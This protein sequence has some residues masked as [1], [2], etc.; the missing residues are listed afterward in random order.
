MTVVLP[1]YPIPDVQAT[2][3]PQPAAS[4]SLPIIPRRVVNS[5]ADVASDR[6]LSVAGAGAFVPFGY[7]AFRTGPL[8]AHVADYNGRLVL[9]LVWC[10]GQVE[11][12]DGLQLSDGSDVPAAIAIT[13]YT[14]DPTQGVDPALSAAIDGWNNA[15][16]S[17]VRGHVVGLAYSVVSIPGNSQIGIPAFVADIRG[18][19]VYDPRDVGQSPTDS[20]TWLY[21]DNPALA[22]ADLE[23]SKLY[24][25]GKSIDWSSVES[26]ADDC[27]ELVQGIE[28]RRTVGLIINS[29]GRVDAWVDTLSTYAGCFVVSEG[30]ATKL[31]SNR[32]PVVSRALTDA[33]IVADDR[34]TPKLTIKLRG[35]S[36]SPTVVHVVYTETSTAEHKD[37]SAYAYMAGVLDGS[38]EW[39]ESV[40]RLPGI[41]RYSQAQ[42]EAVER[43]NALNLTD[44][45]VRFITHDE[46]L[47][48]QV[49]DVI[50][51]TSWRGLTNKM[52]R[53]TDVV[54]VSPGRWQ[55]SATEYQTNVYSDNVETAP[56]FTDT[57]LLSPLDPPIPTGVVAVEE[58]YQLENGTF[59]SRLSITWDAVEYAYLDHFDVRVSDATALVMLVSVPDPEST[60]PPVQDNV[61]YTVNVRTVSTVGASSEWVTINITADG[62]YLIPSDVPALDGFEVGGEVRLNW[63]PSIDVDIW[64]YEIRYCAPAVD[65]DNA[66]LLDRVDALRL[67]TRDVPA[68]SWDFLVKAVDSVGQYSVNPARRQLLVTLDTGAFLVDEHDFSAPILN[69]VREC[70]LGRVDGVRRFVTEM[71]D[72][73]A[74]MFPNVMA[75]Y[76]EPLVTYHSSGSS[77]IL[78]ETWD[79]GTQISGT[80]LAEIDYSALT[81]AVTV[82]LELSTDGVLWDAYANLTAKVTARYARIRIGAAT[83]STIL[84]TIP[85]M[86]V[87]VDAV[88]R[89]ENGASTSS[90]TLA[91]TI[92]CANEYAAAQSILI[93]PL[94]TTALSAVVDNIVVG[95]PTTFDVY[96][97]NVS[98]TQVANDF[99]WHFGGV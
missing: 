82:A 18:R 12:I 76:T 46:A 27:D 96:I 97:F 26:V 66:I 75:A 37:E 70:A 23:S 38:T 61:F 89:E 65:W 54:P 79:A 28:A 62:K 58:V 51:L 81:G 87:R 25:R 50:A 85:A 3:E 45:E 59:Q 60:T 41:N 20:A 71:G 32:P 93:T 24:G 15:L 17:V 29:Q 11:S 35:L 84:A 83:T 43:L 22:L 36:N 88:P 31:V 92:T 68:G 5:V 74:S 77:E 16:V 30:S 13:H 34:G 64:R 39:R 42:R 69:N 53:I 10:L 4:S 33:D 7:G 98:G 19:R 67:V 86:R 47:A 1:D 57:D 80:W 52:L 63:S 49:G 94:G 14:G 40:V 9:L 44:L 8:M 95:N 91:T 55:I 99:I 56:I 90:A 2:P 21:S 73:I 48:D 78:S 72:S 6:M